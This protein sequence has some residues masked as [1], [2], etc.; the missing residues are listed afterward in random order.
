MRRSETERI[1]DETKREGMTLRERER[2]YNE[3]L[4]DM[5]FEVQSE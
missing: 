5:G 3:R 1:Q 4:R 2:G